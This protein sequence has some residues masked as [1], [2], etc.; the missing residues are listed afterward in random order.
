MAQALGYG[1]KDDFDVFYKELSLIEEKTSGGKSGV[2]FFDKIKTSI[3]AMFDD[4]QHDIKKENTAQ[5]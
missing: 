2:S 3:T 1:T 4:S 5:N